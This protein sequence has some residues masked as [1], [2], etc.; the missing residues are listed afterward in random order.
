[1]SNAKH[2]F[3]AFESNGVK[4]LNIIRKR[5]FTPDLQKKLRTWGINDACKMID[6]SRKTIYDLEKENKI[7]TPKIDPETGRK[8]YSLEHINTL[9]DFFN[10]RPRKPNNAET[11]II[12]VTNFKGGV[13][14]TTSTIHAAQYFALKGYRV[15]LIDGDSQASATQCFG[16]IP[17]DDIDVTET[18]LQ[19]LVGESDTISSI[20]K[21]TYW[22]GLD[23][24]PANL[25]LYNAEFELPVKNA[26]KRAQGEN[27]L[28]Y[29]ILKEGIDSIKKEYDII[30]IDCPPSMG[31]ISINAIYA[32]NGLLIPIPPSMLDFTSTVQFFGM[33]K[34]VV[35]RLGVKDYKFVRLLIT[36]YE[37]S[38]NTKMLVDIIRQLYG[39]YVQL[40]VGP[41]SEAVKK[42]GTELRSIYEIEKY[43]GSKKTLD[44]IK[45]AVDQVNAELE[46]VI[47]STWKS[48]N[49]IQ[50]RFDEELSTNV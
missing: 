16:Y 25:S 46:D 18:L 10:T 1:M 9:R 22:H 13:W 11:A 26:L 47:I 44:R 50:L 49:D 31:M 19:Y 20:I 39:R 6:R 32:A 43:A 24:I 42:A 23:L 41:N 36:K 28:F 7:P 37:K 15:L 30:L 48:D 45:Q 33:L 3:S 5:A 35:S 4:A 40:A 17:D 14:K 21:K 27:F 34:D 29:N 12:A 38:E 8:L 2:V